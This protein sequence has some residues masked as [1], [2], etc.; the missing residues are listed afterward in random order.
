INKNYDNFFGVNFDQSLK[1][2]ILSL[3]KQFVFK[4]N[5][6]GI[7]NVVSFLA[8]PNHFLLTQNKLNFIR[9]YGNTVILHGA[10]SEYFHPI[11]QI[12]LSNR[13]NV[14]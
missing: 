14:L 3:D 1:Y 4:A 7:K 12:L 5:E 11:K 9:K 10:D 6:L 13:V 8:K 2:I